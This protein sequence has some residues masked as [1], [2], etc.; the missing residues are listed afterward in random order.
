MR[1]RTSSRNNPGSRWGPIRGASRVSIGLLAFVAAFLPFGVAEANQ[2]ALDTSARKLGTHQ[3]VELV[4]TGRGGVPASGVGAVALNVTVT[5]ATEPSF[6]TVWPTGAPMPLASNLNFTAGQTVPN[7]VIAK[8][9]AGGQISL[10]NSTGSADVIV[11][12]LGWFPEGDSYTG[13]TPARLLDTRD[14]SGSPSPGP[15]PPPG[16]T[17]PPPPPPTDFLDPGTYEG[18]SA[19]R[20]TM[21]N[22]TVGCYW[23]RTSYDYSRLGWAYVSFPGRT[24]VDIS[25]YEA[26]FSFTDECGRMTPLA[27]SGSP[28]AAIVPGDHVVNHHIQSGTYKTTLAEP[29]YCGWTR[30]SGFGGGAAD[31]ID[32]LSISDA[33]EFFVTIQPGDAGFQT[34]GCGTW[35]RVS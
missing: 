7:M 12:V 30:L 4:V 29:G 34:D 26:S 23:E 21:E 2:A 6:L 9:G 14:P 15:A 33:G 27:S 35:T 5:N 1:Y 18:I 32:G 11:D 13:L 31:L 28:A 19:G 17:P 25:G 22:A 10:F 20:Y 3:A 8:V 24:V 16:P